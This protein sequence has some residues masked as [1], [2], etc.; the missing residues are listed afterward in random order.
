MHFLVA[1]ALAPRTVHFDL[2]PAVFSFL[3]VGLLAFM[4]LIVY[5]AVRARRKRRQ[6]LEQFAMESGF[7]FSE[8]PDPGAAEELAQVHVSG[9]Q[10]GLA[11]RPRFS[12]VLRGSA[13]GTEAIICDRTVGS[14]K[15]QS[16]STI[17]AFKVPR[18]V[19]EFM[20]CHET[21]LW[22]L[23]DKLGY[24]DIDLDGAPDFS[25]RFFL[26]GKDQA[27]VRA[28]FTPD[29]TQAFEQLAPT[30]ELYVCGAGSWLVFYRPGRLILVPEYREILQQAE[31]LVNAFRRAQSSHVF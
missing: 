25:R 14:G 28:L 15:S 21:M 9:P 23:A 26:H 1:F 16:T 11:S 2:P 31:M 3:W 29:V 22:R 8:T 13:A 4:V 20:L 27:A 6:A 5:A 7:L 10:T 24:S 17:I 19:P 12:N 30:A 18:P